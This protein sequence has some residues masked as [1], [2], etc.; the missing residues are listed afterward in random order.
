MNPGH[1]LAVHR[2]RFPAAH[3]PDVLTAHENTLRCLA[4]DLT[5]AAAR[6]QIALVDGDNV[7]YDAVRWAVSDALVMATTASETLGVSVPQALD[8]RLRGQYMRN[9]STL[10]PTMWAYPLSTILS[11]TTRKMVSVDGPAGVYDL[12]RWMM[13]DRHTVAFH[14]PD[15]REIVVDFAAPELVAQFPRLSPAAAA[16][17]AMPAVADTDTTDGERPRQ[18]IDWVTQ[19]AWVLSKSDSVTADADPELPV[20]QFEPDVRHRIRTLLGLTDG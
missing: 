7:D 8:D 1:P 12:L 11:V 18:I 17:P 15:V 9:D 19:M 4:A 6:M 10:G 20:R 2:I 14:D 13:A 16:H 5:D 3:K